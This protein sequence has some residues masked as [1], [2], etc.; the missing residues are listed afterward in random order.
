MRQ[1][2]IR[3]KESIYPYRKA[4]VGFYEALGRVFPLEQSDTRLYNR[5][6]S[7]DNHLTPFE[8]R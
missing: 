6:Q 8:V 5:G 1:S 7:V 3:V 2:S 4:L